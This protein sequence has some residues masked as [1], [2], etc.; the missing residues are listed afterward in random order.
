MSDWISS[1]FDNGGSSEEIDID[2]K[3]MEPYRDEVPRIN[4]IHTIGKNM[5]KDWLKEYAPKT[6]SDLVV[7]KPKL[8]QLNSWLQ[9]ASKVVGEASILLITGP[10]GVGK[11]TALKVLASVQ[12]IHSIEWETPLDIDSSELAGSR[13][14]MQSQ[15]SKFEAFLMNSSRYS[16]VLETGKDMKK[17][18]IVKEFPNVFALHPNLFQDILRRYRVMGRVPIV[19]SLPDQA[20][21]SGGMFPKQFLEELNVQQI[22]FNKVPNKSVMKALKRICTLNKD[23]SAPS[24]DVLEKIVESVHGDI[25][26]AILQLHYEF[27]HD[28]CETI[29]HHN[30][31]SSGQVSHKQRSSKTKPAT[32]TRGSN[33]KSSKISKKRFNVNRTFHDFEVFYKDVQLPIFQRVGRLLYPKISQE[34]AKFLT[35]D[36]EEI[37]DQTLSHPGRLF[38]MVL[39]NY[40]K[41]FRD[42]NDCC[43]AIHYSSDADSMMSEFRERELTLPMALSTM[44]RG[45]MTCKSTVNR[46]WTPLTNQEYSSVRQRTRAMRERV[47]DT[48]PKYTMMPRD[49]AMDILPIIHSGLYPRLV[50]YPCADEMCN[51]SDDEDELGRPAEGSTNLQQTLFAA[52]DPVSEIQVSSSKSLPVGK[53][54]AKN[55]KDEEEMVHFMAFK[56]LKVMMKIKFLKNKWMLGL[57]MMLIYFT[58]SIKSKPSYVAVTL[59]CFHQN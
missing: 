13:N 28:K 1:C 18:I 52:L 37:V 9:K 50:S 30:I 55:T 54:Q 17:L 29:K 46:K 25:R 24:A 3:K 33:K 2:A 47:I 22:S 57:R 59:G 42:M 53:S 44:V 7:Q 32:S 5:T 23:S 51:T 12:K 31:L 56:N 48:D 21:G 45:F 8:D 43:R 4:Y 10:P 26:S 38:H 41:V 40:L 35:H 11:S 27:V 34:D 20:E 49:A 14:F 15:A 16:S 19:F 36:P 6:P 58:I 39:E